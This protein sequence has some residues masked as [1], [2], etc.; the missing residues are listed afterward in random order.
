MS[1]RFERKK[2]Y[3]N[4]MFETCVE[5]FSHPFRR[6]L[7]RKWL[8]SQ[9]HRTYILQHLLVSSMEGTKN[10]SMQFCTVENQPEKI[11]PARDFRQTQ[12]TPG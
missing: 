2:S 4:I 1:K 9:N 11:N 3:Q 12:A 6:I 8:H 10:I 5:L 7:P